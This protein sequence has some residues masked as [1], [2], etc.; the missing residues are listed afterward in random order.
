MRT[1]Y[2]DGV[3]AVRLSKHE[4]TS[5]EKTLALVESLSNMQP[6]RKS[7]SDAAMAATESLALILKIAGCDAEEFMPLVDGKTRP[8]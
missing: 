6:I 1:P 8:E 7:L 4:T 3:I 2:R 5:V